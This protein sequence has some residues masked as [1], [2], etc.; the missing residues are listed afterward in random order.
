MTIA[1]SDD[2]PGI[3][4]EQLERV[5][6]RFHRVDEGRARERGGTGLGLAIARAIVEAHGGRIWAESPPGG[7]ATITLELPGYRPTAGPHAG[8]LTVPDPRTDPH[9][10]TGPRSRSG[11]RPSGPARGCC[12]RWWRIEIDDQALEP[13]PAA[14]VYTASLESEI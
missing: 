1:V 5:F 2:G 11:P 4:P 13:T 7:G 9:A 8:G 14:T 6:E 12:R 3:P 10:T